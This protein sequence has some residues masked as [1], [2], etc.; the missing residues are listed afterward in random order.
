MRVRP[1][2][3]LIERPPVD[4]LRDERDPDDFLVVLRPVER[5]RLPERPPVALLVERR[6]RAWLA[7]LGL[8]VDSPR[9][10][11]FLPDDLRPRPVLLALRRE[12]LLAADL[13]PRVEALRPREPPLDDL[14]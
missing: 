12:L 5:P 3:P 7:V 13:R 8:P 10:L 4:P 6:E 11:V 14:R 1:L 9:R 2:P